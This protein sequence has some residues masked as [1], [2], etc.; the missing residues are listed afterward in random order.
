M[1]DSIAA[2]N[3]R[4]QAPI[5]TPKSN[6]Y[7]LAW[8]QH[9]FYVGGSSDALTSGTQ[10]VYSTAVHADGSIDQWRSVAVTPKLMAFFGGVIVNG[11]MVLAGGNTATPID[12]LYSAKVDRDGNVARLNYSSI[13]YSSFRY[14]AVV[15]DGHGMV[16][17]IGG[18]TDAVGNEVWSGLLVPDA[19]VSSWRQAQSLPASIQGHCAIIYGDYIYCLGGSTNALAGGCIDE[20]RSAHIEPNGGLGPWNLVGNLPVAMHKMTVVV[21]KDRLIVCGGQDISSNNLATM[22]VSKLEPHGQLGGFVA[23]PAGI[24]VAHRN[25][26]AALVGRRLFLAAGFTTVRLDTVTSIDLR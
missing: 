1:G 26:S 5:P 4:T 13:P 24:P 18:N 11:Q 16:Y 12:S 9:L 2:N 6:G 25:A 20:V 15:L 23:D 10:E 21:Y 17:V 19:G 7:L 3:W 22:Y 14:P 8:G